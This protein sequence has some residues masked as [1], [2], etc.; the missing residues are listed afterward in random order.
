M[1]WLAKKGKHVIDC[2]LFYSNNTKDQLKSNNR[3]CDCYLSSL[4]VV[5]KPKMKNKK[6]GRQRSIRYDLSRKWSWANQKSAWINLHDNFFACVSLSRPKV[7]IG[8]F[9]VQLLICF[10]IL[11]LKQL[12]HNIKSQQHQSI[13]FCSS[14]IEIE[15][16]TTW[17]EIN[18]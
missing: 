11:I 16:W 15:Q 2:W 17:D 8:T 1:A 6:R 18:N 13:Y 4:S 9:L 12:P 7:V 5:F 10:D 14:S 3:H